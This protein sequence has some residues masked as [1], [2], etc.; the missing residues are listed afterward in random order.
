MSSSNYADITVLFSSKEAHLKSS[1]LVLAPSLRPQVERYPMGL[2]LGGDE[3][4]IVSDEE[5]PDPGDG[6]APRRDK[7]RFAKVRAPILFFQLGLKTLI[8]PS[9]DLRIKEKGQAV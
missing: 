5:L 8:L 6:P 4:D 3:I 1:R 2:L 7:G 9:S